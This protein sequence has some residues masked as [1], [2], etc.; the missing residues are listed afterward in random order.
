M[1][2]KNQIEMAL[3]ASLQIDQG[4]PLLKTKNSLSLGVMDRHRKGERYDFRTDSLKSL[5]SRLRSTRAFPPSRTAYRCVT[6]GTHRIDAPD[7]SA[8]SERA[9]ERAGTP[10]H[11]RR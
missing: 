10:A 2:E 1:V 4:I 11:S 3:S 5:T 6:G 7:R 9:A 8:T